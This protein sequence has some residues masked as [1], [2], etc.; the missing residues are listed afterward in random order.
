MHVTRHV[1]LNF[2]VDGFLHADQLWN[3]NKQ[4]AII[5]IVTPKLVFYELNSYK[6]QIYIN[7]FMFSSLY[8]S[9]FFYFRYIFSPSFIIR[10]SGI[11]FPEDT[12]AYLIRVLIV[13][14][15]TSS[16]PLEVWDQKEWKKRCNIKEISLSLRKIYRPYTK[17]AK[18]KFAGLWSFLCFSY[19]C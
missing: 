10:K 12:H 16:Q 18:T 6:S 3:K 13:S 17:L 5:T 19:W 1:L 15:S 4:F 14:L 2:N 9:F 8:S 11:Y 7:G